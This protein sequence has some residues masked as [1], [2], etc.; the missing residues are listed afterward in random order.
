MNNA[1][2]EEILRFWFAD[3]GDGF[4]VECH[5]RL[6]YSGGS[7]FDDKIRQRFG[8]QVAL[9]LAQQITDWSQTPEGALALVILLDQFTR[10]IYRA[11]ANAFAGDAQAREMVRAGLAARQDRHLTF[12]QRCFFY[13]PLEHSESLSDQHQCVILF[14]DMLQ[15][16]PEHGKPFIKSNLRFAVHHREIIE[17]FG[18][19]PHRNT[20]LNRASTELELEYLQ[21]GGARFGQ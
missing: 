18:R 8:E 11:S 16:V 4:D 7:A 19:F 1:V 13:M 20:V 14:E 5:N 12:V 9:A 17:R 10:N 2:R 3:I 21:K 6:W 15:Q